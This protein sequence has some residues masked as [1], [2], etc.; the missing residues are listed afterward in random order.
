MRTFV[1]V[2]KGRS[3]TVLQATVSGASGSYKI[4]QHSVGGRVEAGVLFRDREARKNVGFEID[5]RRRA[6]DLTH[7]GTCQDFLGSYRRGYLPSI[8]L[9]AADQLEGPSIA[10]RVT[11]G[12]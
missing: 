12:G 6:G 4:C 8:A 1:P 9:R 7:G 11:D 10:L 5:I 3:S 2:W